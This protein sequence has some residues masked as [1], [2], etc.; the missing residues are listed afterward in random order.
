MEETKN[1]LSVVI[2]VY[3]EA[4]TISKI[5]KKVLKRQEVFEVIIVDDGSSDDSFKKISKFT[6][7]KVRIIKH[8]KNMGKGAAMQT[9][10]KNAF[11]KWLIFQDADL[12]LYPKD[13]KKL[14]KP[15]ID[16]KADFVIGNRWKNHNGYFLAQTGNRILTTLVNIL[17]G[18]KV[19]DSYCG[20]KVASTKIWKELKLKSLR[21]EIEAEIIAKVALKKLRISE[22]DV[23]YTPRFYKDGKKIRARDVFIGAK[24]LFIL[25]FANL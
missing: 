25:R 18:C 5:L 7:Q 3:N 12:E 15:L 11:G 24:K 20:Y 9:G 17:F 13:Y 16:Q 10:I 8:Q 19:E 4:K 21:F 1:C 6:N 22:V 2:S 23:K 14:L